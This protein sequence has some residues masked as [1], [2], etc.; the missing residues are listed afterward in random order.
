M[1]SRIRSFSF[2]TALALVF[3]QAVPAFAYQGEADAPQAPSFRSL[4]EIVV[5]ARRSEERLQ[6]VPVSITAMSGDFLERQNVVDAGSL[7]Q[8]TPNLTIAAQPSS[9]SAAAVYIRGIGN[10]EPSALS[11]QG[12]GIYL[13]GVYLARA[14][15]VIFDLIDL[16]RVE[17]LRGP[18]GTLFGRNTI[19]G[20]VQFVSRKPSDDFGLS[21]KTGYGRF[22]D[23]YVRT[24]V[25]SGYLGETP[26]KLSIS[27]SHRQADGFVDNLFTKSSK[28]PGAMN[29][30]SVAVALQGDFDALTVNYNFDFDDRRGTPSFFQ[31]THATQ[32]VID[33][34]SQ[35][36]LF[37][38]KP[39]MISPDRLKKVYQEGYVDRKG[40]FR[41]DS[42]SR[43]WGNSL[44]LNYD[45]SSAL[46]LKSITGY[47]EFSQDTIPALGGNGGLMGVVLDPV[48]YDP[49]ILPVNPYIGN[50]A[51]QKQW[52]FSQ[53]F[54]A[55][56]SVG[57]I[58]YLAGLYY[59]YEKSSEHN[60]QALTFVL[61]GGQAGFNL[62]P[63]QAFSGTSESIAAFTQVSWKPA[64]LDDRLEL[65]GG[66]RYTEDKKTATLM[67]D[68][69]PNVRGSTKHDN[70]SW[71]TSVSYKFTDDVMGFARVSTGY[72]SGG[73]N[74]RASEIN[75]FE[76][77]KAMAYELGLK[78]EFLDRRVQLNI[79]GFL[80]DY[81][82]L[83]V[84]Q[85]AAGSGGAVT[86]IV[87]AGKVQLKG[88]EAELVAIP[89]D[90][91]RFDGTV[92]YV[93][94]KYKRFDFLDPTSNQIIDVSDM[95]ESNYAPKWNLRIGGEY[96]HELDQGLVRLRVDYSYRSKF[97]YHPLDIT[98]PF[99]D[100]IY[101]HADHNLKARLS[102]EGITVGKSTV[103]IGIWGDNLTN[104]EN[105]DYSIDFGSLGFA[106]S[107][108]KKP[109]T[110][111]IDVKFTF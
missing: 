34:F 3:A 47:R 100:L 95:G 2:T 96:S 27:A 67:G 32:E 53:E 37:G 91:L 101:T 50:N 21:V 69:K 111:G 7:T 60:Q 58:T 104:Q 19:G 45:V 109:R 35:S 38:G 15:G 102:F 33:Y 85:F 52:Q 40:K 11:E 57:E 42:R 49:S 76:P 89:A 70:V 28:D 61:P 88:F 48:T 51:P 24:R 16:E 54:Q 26:L 98:A 43:N 55:L 8:L 97:K 110:Y 17:V 99:N 56:G 103:D 30:D 29:A 64:A 65:T 78:S 90:G 31:M 46:T 108:F 107:T 66:L 86:Y 94:K 82:D 18:Q 63:V 83:Q 105:I 93:E 81:D 73:I 77:E 75:T 44:T 62:T 20:A 87:N 12:V 22:N 106:G 79:S 13:D 74:P 92:G 9:L 80:T 36:P 72:R 6:D 39:F 1:S 5:T 84:Q 25:D 59:F 4:D 23:W 68:V 14:A 71:L 41:Y 10:S